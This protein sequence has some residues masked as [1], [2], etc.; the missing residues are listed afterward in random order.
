MHLPRRDTRNTQQ[1]KPWTE[2][3]AFEGSLAIG[4]WQETAAGK[5]LLQRADEQVD[6][7]QWGGELREVFDQAVARASELLT[8]RQGDMIYVAQ[9]V[10]PWRLQT[11]DV[12]R[13]VNGNEEILYCKIK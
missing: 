10:Q 5:W 3:V 8:I 1:G 11:N 9:N 2:A 7:R 12:I 4:N 6:E 13:A